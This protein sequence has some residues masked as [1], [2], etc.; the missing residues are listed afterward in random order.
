MYITI[1]IVVSLVALFVVYF[2]MS[3]KKFRNMPK[4][5]DS[6]NIIH[7]DDKNF[8][9]TT[10]KGIA[11]IDFWAEWCMPCKMMSPV[12]NDVANQAD[13]NVRI[14]KV[15]VESQPKLSV[16]FNV[17]SIPTLVL[18]QNG[19]EINRFVGVKTKEFLLNQIGQLN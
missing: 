16:K 12:L 18:M 6:K 19:K 8:Q 4:V 10:N 7:L 1:I 17:R 15:D 13:E 2:T 11:L 3:I 14:C 9:Q 5:E